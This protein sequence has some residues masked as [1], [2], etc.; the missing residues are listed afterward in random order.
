[1]RKILIT[2]AL[3]Y[4]NGELHLGSMLEHVQ[5]DIWGRFQKM[6]G[7][8]CIA[9]CGDD[10]H[11]AAIMIKA[12]KLGI[13][14]EAMIEET[15][16]SHEQDLTGFDV[17]YDYYHSTH[18]EEN[19][20]LASHIYNVLNDK[21]YITSKDVEQAFD[22]EKQMFLPDRFIKGQCPRCKAED[23][24]GDNC[25]V[26]G[27]TY[28]PSEVLNPISVL[29]GT[30]PTKKISKHL[31]FDLPQFEKSL[32]SFIN[33]DSLQPQVRNKLKE[34]FDDGLRQWDISRDAPYFGFEIPGETGK[35][36][37]VW[38]D[39]PIGYMASFKKY[40]ELHQIDFD[41]FWKTDS[42]AELYHFIGKDI[43][44][45]H[46]LF[47]PAMLEG[48]DYRKPSAIFAH[49]FL[50][51]NG[52]KMS[53]S[54][55][56]FITAR[57][58]LNHLEA[59]YIRFYYACKLNAEIEDIDLN[60]QDFAARINSDLVGKIVNIASRSAGFI[61]KRFDGRLAAEVDNLELLQSVQAQAE[62]IANLFETREFSKA[63]RKIS[64]IADLANQYIADKAPWVMVKDEARLDEAHQVLTTALNLFRQIILFLK[65]VIP[66][67][68]EK[69]EHFL[70]I[71]PLKW[72]DHQS[73]LMSHPINPFKPLVKRIE[74]EQINALLAENQ[75]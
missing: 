68:V 47:W 35:Y 26:C 38:L 18:S 34:W 41:A 30:A 19:Q 75:T 39:A 33:S 37:Y 60:F 71:E 65:P 66:A 40:C 61:H 4:A 58:Y 7:N 6:R 2:S 67:I 74:E 31:F 15:K 45:F 28:S 70:N 23:Q 8:Q 49:G 62:T 9:V 12:E 17:A 42:E 64:E 20:T 5:T 13:T 73:L 3:P 16:A 52:Q 44:Y 55:G 14:A 46:T 72:S 24:Y 50:T 48:A 32:Q 43:L 56:T 51:I 53:K 1:M 29:S 69:A 25:E 36:F 21:G 11:G 59:S 63:M 10:A 57:S 27:A 22:E 54:R